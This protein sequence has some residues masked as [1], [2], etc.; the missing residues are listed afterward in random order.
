MFFTNCYIKNILQ[1]KV[2]LLKNKEGKVFGVLEIL[3][4]KYR[5][6][7]LFCLLWGTDLS[8]LSFFRLYK[9]KTSFSILS[10]NS[11]SY[12]CFL[13]T[14]QAVVQQEIWWKDRREK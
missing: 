6:L 11:T 9:I 13:V 1:S 3:G 8:N 4:N 14:S 7:F 10:L 12:Y 5:K 2:F